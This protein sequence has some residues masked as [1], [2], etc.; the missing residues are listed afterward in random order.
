MLTKFGV[1]LLVLAFGF[2]GAASAADNVGA[3]NGKT[4][5]LKPT[6]PT[7]GVNAPIPVGQQEKGAS[8]NLP[9]AKDKGSEQ[10]AH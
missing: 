4:P 7:Q 1:A 3:A 2:G 5:D 10:P 6:A 8:A 9:A